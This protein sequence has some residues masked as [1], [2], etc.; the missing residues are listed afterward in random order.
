MKFFYDLLPVILFFVAYKMYDIFVATT[1]AIIATLAQIAIVYLKHRKLE[2]MLVFNGLMITVL[3]GLTI[4]LKDKYFIMWKPSV[5]YW[6]F[7]L[8]LIFAD[9]F[10]NRN[11]VQLALGKQMELSKTVWKKINIFTALFF[12]L[13]GFINLFVVYNFTENTWVNFKLFGLTG[14]LFFYMIAIAIYISKTNKDR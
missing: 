14:L 1:V 13:L 2:K 10:F 11:L 12:I 7:A 9:Q 8:A 6:A 4:L 5:I 3:G